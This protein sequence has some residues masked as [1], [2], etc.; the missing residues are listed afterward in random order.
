MTSN[1]AFLLNNDHYGL[2]SRPCIEAET[3]LKAS[4]AQCA[5]AS[6][7]ALEL[8]VKWNYSAD[9]H[10]KYPAR[11]GLTNLIDNTLFKQM[12]GKALHEKLTYIVKLGNVA[13]HTSDRKSVV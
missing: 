10:L 12:V 13:A 4:S 1:F 2:F 6:R 9:K 11:E 7:R 3:A 5:I 8:A